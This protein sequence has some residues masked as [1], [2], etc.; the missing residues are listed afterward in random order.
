[1]FQIHKHECILFSKIFWSTLGNHTHI[2]M[3]MEKVHIHTRAIIRK[4]VKRHRSDHYFLGSP[5]CCLMF[6]RSNWYA[7]T[8]IPAR[9]LAFSRVRE[10]L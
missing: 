2:Y 8:G 5:E 9:L 1:M 4:L 10:G 6:L 3:N 7:E